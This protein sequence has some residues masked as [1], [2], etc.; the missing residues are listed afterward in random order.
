[1]LFEKIKEKFVGKNK[2][3]GYSLMELLVSM[4]I[5]GMLFLALNQVMFSSLRISQE[6]YKRA[7]Y[8]ESVTEIFDFIKRDIRNA[9]VILNCENS[10][11]EIEHEDQI[12][13]TICGESIC[14]EKFNEAT[15]NYEVIKKSTDFVYIRNVRF[16]KLSV[17]ASQNDSGYTDNT[18][19]VTIEAV[20]VSNQGEIE[21]ARDGDLQIDV[22]QIIVS[23]RNLKI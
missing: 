18:I 15:S 20:P 4:A 2:K 19:I 12:R 8:R 11:C 7:L 5:F 14:R 1:M 9:N 6:N 17:D 10:A 23:T 13:W 21:E 16:E 3:D 22:Q